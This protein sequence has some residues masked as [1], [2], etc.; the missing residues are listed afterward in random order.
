MIFGWSFHPSRHQGDRVLRVSVEHPKPI[1]EKEID[2]VAGGFAE[3]PL[4]KARRALRQKGRA[5]QYDPKL[6]GFP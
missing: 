1:V 6:S 2:A 5:R 3:Q 4:A